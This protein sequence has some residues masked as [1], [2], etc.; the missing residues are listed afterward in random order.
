[1]SDNKKNP[2][3]GETISDVHYGNPMIIEFESGDKIEMEFCRVDGENT[4]LTKYIK[5]ENK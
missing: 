5:K 4:A 3:I 1:M 2:I